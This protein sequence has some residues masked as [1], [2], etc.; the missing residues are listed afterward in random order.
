MRLVGA[1]IGGALNC[2]GGKFHHLKGYALEA[3]GLTTKIGVYLGNGFSAE[4]GVRLIGGDIGGDLSCTYGKF[5]KSDKYALDAAGLKVQGSV[6]LND[7]FSAKGEVRLLGVS[8]EGT[9]D[10]AGGQF[11]NEDADGREYALNAEQVKTGGHVYLND[12]KAHGS[13]PFSARGRVRFANADIG[14]NFNCKGG[15]FFHSGKGS[16]IAAGGLRSRGA[17][18][19]SDDC[20]V[21]GDVDLHVAQIGNFVCVAKKCERSK[22]IIN[23]SSTKAVA[24]DDDPKAWRQFEFILDGFTYDAFFGEETL[25][26]K[27]RLEWLTSR[28]TKRRVKG[29]EVEVLFSPLP[30]EQAAKV[31]FDMGQ[32]NDA[33]KILLEKERRQTADERT[34]WWHKIW[35]GLWGEFAGYGY[36]WEWTIFWSLAIFSSGGVCFRTRMIWGALFPTNR[37]LL[38]ARNSGIC[39]QMCL[40]SIRN[41][42]RW[43]FRRMCSFRCSPCI[44]SRFGILLPEAKVFPRGCSKGKKL[45]DGPLAE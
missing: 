32:D 20:T 39:P 23:L 11:D 25:K 8:I 5:C 27:R 44:R 24:V 30:Y 45:S 40:R 19:L 28:P 7:G 13:K 21:Q 6:F 22:G 34:P 29:K 33:R 26:D 41:S 17:V 16:T 2:K 31:L 42:T 18:F 38:P 10:C 35:R 15:Q 4:G 1:S 3:P 37:P 14:R 9:L 12:G 43:F 36:Q